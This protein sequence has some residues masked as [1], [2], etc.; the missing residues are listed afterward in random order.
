MRFK[1]DDE[2]AASV[3]K[4]FSPLKAEDIAEIILFTVTRP[5]HVN[6]SDLTVLPTSQANASIVK[7]DLGY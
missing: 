5:G 2:R 4:G 1:G 7:K 6:V 3:Y